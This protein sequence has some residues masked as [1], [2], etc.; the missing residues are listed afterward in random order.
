[1]PSSQGARI[2]VTGH[3]VSITNGP[4]AEANELVGGLAFIEV[5]SLAEAK[6]WGRR[7]AMVHG[8]A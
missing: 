7:L 6:E 5:R 4:F 1:M 8:D 3:T 2:D